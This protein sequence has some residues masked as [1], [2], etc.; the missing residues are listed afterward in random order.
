MQYL[1]S[2]WEVFGVNFWLIL[3]QISTMYHATFTTVVKNIVS[4]TGLELKKHQAPPFFLKDYVKKNP[5]PVLSGEAF[6][7]MKNST[8]IPC[9]I[10]LCVYNGFWQCTCK[11]RLIM[12]NKSF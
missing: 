10:A 11:Y 12:E 7:A 3:I 4:K 6:K 1:D 2:G 5:I 9:K 8:K